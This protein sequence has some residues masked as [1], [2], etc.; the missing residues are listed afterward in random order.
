MATPN[1]VLCTCDQLRAFDT[2][3]YGNAEVSTPHLDRLAAGGVRFETAVTNFPVCMAARSV[4]L[5][6]Q[7]NRTCTGGAANV[8]RQRADGGVTLPEYPAHG[9]P[10]LPDPALPELLRAAGYDTAVIGKWHVHA[11][12]HDL[13][14]DRYLIPRVHHAHTGQL[15]TEDGGPEF[16]P[17][18]YSLDFE[19]DRVTRFLRE[20]ANADRPFFLYCN[21]SPPHGPVADVPERRRALFGPA[22]VTLRPNTRED[23][24]LPEQDHWFRIYRHDYRYYDLGLPY[25]YALPDGYS[26]RHLIA[27]YRGAAAWMDAAVGRVLDALDTAGLAGNTLVVFLSDHGDNLGS[28]GLVQKGTVNQEAVRVP[29]IARGPGIERGTVVRDGV[30]SLVDLAPTLLRAAGLEAPAH[31]AGRDLLQEP[32]DCAL[33]ETEHEVAIRTARHLYAL[34]LVD[35]RLGPHPTRLFDLEAD[36]YEMHNL[37]GGSEAGDIAEGL[38]ARLRA[39]DEEAPWMASC[40]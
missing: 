5:S 6:G 38:D 22:D 17:D 28:H 8:V 11:W 31:M 19:A 4:L 16:A 18:G 39:W 33:I 14:F 2:G 21:F 3:C 40:V 34:P 7:Y 37:A 24:P 32:P 15:Y 26:L 20:R 13:G 27:E 25:T 30:A 10:H 36:P 23:T 29:L 12:P 9:R 35:R 1:I